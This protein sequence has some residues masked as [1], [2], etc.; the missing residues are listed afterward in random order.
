MRIL[1]RAFLFADKP[2]CHFHATR[3]RIHRL[4]GKN[5]FCSDSFLR[6]DPIFLAKSLSL[7][8]NLKSR[9]LGT[10]V[11]GHIVKLGFTN[12]IFLQNIL[13]TAYSKRGFFGCGLRVFD[14]MAERNLVSWTLIVSAA[15]Q[16]GELDMGLKMYVDMTTNGFMPNEFAVGSV[17]KAC[18]SMGASEFGYSIHCFALKIGIEK[19]PFVG[20]SVLN[21]YAKLGDV[22]AAERVFYSLSSD[23]VG[24]WN[25]MIGGYAH[26]GYGFE[27]L[28]VVSSM[29]FEGITMDKYTLINALQG[30]SLVAD[31]D[32]GRQIHGLI[33]RSEVECSI[34]IV[35]ALIDMYIKSSGMDYAFKVFERMADKDVISWNTLFGG[36]SENKNPGQTASL[37]HKFILSG[38]RPNHVT[39]SILLRQCGKL[40]DLDLGLQLQ[41]LALH[42]GFLDEENVTSSL[43]YMFCRCGAVEMAHSVFDNVSYKN[44][45]TWNELLSGYCFNCCDADV[46]KTFCNIW[47]SGVEVNGCTFFYVLETCCRSENRQMVG[48]IHGAIIKTGFSSC[49]YICSTLIKSYVN[50][51]QLD[52][53]FEFFNGAERLDMASWGAMMSALVHQGHNH[54]AVT[55]FHS[56]VEA[57]EKPDEYILGTILNS[58][59]AIGAYQ[60]T[61]SIHP[62]VI[63]LGFDTEVYVA[64][65]VIDAYAKCGDIKGAR[66]AFDQSFNSND[67]IVYNT[68]IMAYARHGLVSEAMEIFDKMKLANLQPS[69]ATF[70]SVM[71]ACSHK[72]LVDKGCLLFK[73]MDSQ[74]GMQPSPDCYGC[75]VDMLSRNGHLEDAKHVIE[76]MPF[77]PSPTVYR[78]LLSGC[79]IHGNKELG[80]WASEKLLILLPKN[81]A[82]H[83]LLSKVY[84]EDGCW[85]SAAIVRR[86]MTEKQVL[87]DPGYSWIETWS[88]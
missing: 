12:D 65:A 74:Y 40:L 32:I 5:H 75:L 29:L 13:I 76:I 87:K 78:S 27:A 17:M 83:V 64:S 51:G 9:V 73:S 24:C 72:G 71:S 47:E 49:G 19:N 28:N 82:A 59:A 48:Q 44:I 38:S 26:C 2:S 57:G 61:K 66:M 85:E 11:H 33:I 31:F 6:K 60:R 62:F 88:S 23:D 55:I 3:K 56:L 1:K 67:V 4:C 86:G 16:N 84:S 8:E 53:S 7:S 70:V 45:T 39:F 41:C 20:C 22:A 14:E 37:F 34:S 77:Q 10:Q 81:D 69:Q 43:I 52:N 79:R 15:I 25:A 42:C 35:N 36:F 80:E 21:F 58:C 68:L 46:L 54:E 63:K 18:V 30:C 50:F